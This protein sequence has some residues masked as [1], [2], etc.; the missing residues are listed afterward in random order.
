MPLKTALIGISELK[1]QQILLHCFP[2]HQYQKELIIKALQQEQSLAESNAYSPV[3]VKV[4]GVYSMVNGNPAHNS[5]YQWANAS[6]NIQG[7]LV[8]LSL[9]KLDNTY[10]RI[11]LCE[12]LPIWCDYLSIQNQIKDSK[13]L[14]EFVLLDHNESYQG[15]QGRVD[16]IKNEQHVTGCFSYVF[17]TVKFEEL[18]KIT[19]DCQYVVCNSIFISMECKDLKFEL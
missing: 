10:F 3:T 2:V 18:L 15:L 13:H 16:R 6:V 17:N 8:F 9:Q 1:A 14:S 11:I 7:E 12:P 5:Y 19:S 4:S